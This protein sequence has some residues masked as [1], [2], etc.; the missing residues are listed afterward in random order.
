[1]TNMTIAKE[2]GIMR[3]PDCDITSLDSEIHL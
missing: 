2:A 1:M 3:K